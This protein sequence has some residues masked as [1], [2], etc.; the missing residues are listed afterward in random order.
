[1]KYGQAVAVG[2]GAVPRMLLPQACRGAPGAPGSQAQASHRDGDTQQLATD[3]WGGGRV[4]VYEGAYTSVGANARGDQR[5]RAISSVVPQAPSTSLGICQVH[6]TP[7][8]QAPGILLSPLRQHQCWDSEC[9]APHQ[10]CYQRALR[11]CPAVLSW[12]GQ[13]SHEW[14]CF[15]FRAFLPG[16]P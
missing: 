1:M 3:I 6:W 2:F 10:A 14:P 15:S 13:T 8:Q 7:S 9:E 16:L 11:G 4:Y 5:T 12:W